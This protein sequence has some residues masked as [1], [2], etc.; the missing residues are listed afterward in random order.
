[1]KCSG[2]WKKFCQ[3]G[4][5]AEPYCAVRAGEHAIDRIAG[6]HAGFFP[7]MR[8]FSRRFV[9]NTYS[10]VGA[11][12][13]FSSRILKHAVNGVAAQRFGIFLIRHILPEMLR[14][15]FKP[16]QSFFRSELDNALLIFEHGMDGLVSD[17]FLVTLSTGAVNNKIQPVETVQPVPGSEPE[18]SLAVL[19]NAVDRVLRKTFFNFY[20]FGS[21][22]R[23]PDMFGLLRKS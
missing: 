16:A 9:K 10:V 12:P 7:E 21:I 4:A 14:F 11:E 19:K 22:M 20:V 8:E 3:T 6:E 23:E 15:P 1:M 18:K 17:V 5:G 2:F 13:E